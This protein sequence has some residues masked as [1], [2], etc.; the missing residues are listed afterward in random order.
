MRHQATSAT[1]ELLG[2]QRRQDRR[3]R[4]REHGFL[5]G[6]RIQ[7][8]EHRFLHGQILECALLHVPCSVEGLGEAVA[9]P[10]APAYV[11]D[12]LAVEQ[13]VRGELFQRAVDKSERG[14]DGIRIGVMK[15][16]LVAA[17]GKADGP[18]SAD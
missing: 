6:L 1:G 15:G 2:K 9:R 14:L 3:A 16:N 12:T 7:L 11:R 18:R 13:I 5:R 4:A 8:R 17:T 10:D